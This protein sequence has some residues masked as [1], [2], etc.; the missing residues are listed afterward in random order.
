MMLLRRLKVPLNLLLLQS[1]D[2]LS[3]VGWKQ[4]CAVT[5]ESHQNKAS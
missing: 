5:I 1:M 2:L 4:R 3:V